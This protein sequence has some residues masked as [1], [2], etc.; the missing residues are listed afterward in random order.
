MILPVALTSPTVVI[1]PPMIFAVALIVVP[2]I[3]LAPEILPPEPA[4]L[5]LPNVPLPVAL[6]APG[7]YKL[8]PVI[9]V[10]TFKSLTTLPDKLKLA[11]FNVS[12]AL[13][14]PPALTLVTAFTLAP[15]ISPVTFK[16][17]RTLPD[18]LKSPVLTLPPVILPNAL[19]SPDVDILP[20]VTVPVALT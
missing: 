17:L 5:I 12:N 15:V 3:T 2:E 1:F 20:P 16:L 7:V 13:T 9:L 6:T 19:T 8:P 10:V 18:K 14:L 4:V 11:P